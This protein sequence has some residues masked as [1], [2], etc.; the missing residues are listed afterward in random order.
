MVYSGAIKPQSLN[1]H[2]TPLTLTHLCP[3]TAGSSACPQ[4]AEGCQRYRCR[5]DEMDHRSGPYGGRRAETE[6]GKGAGWPACKGLSGRRGLGGLSWQSHSP[7]CYLPGWSLGAELTL[8]WRCVEFFQVPPQRA[9][10]A[11]LERGHWCEPHFTETEAQRSYV[12]CTRS[13]C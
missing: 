1:L 6:V 7:P 4:G 13:H 9:L 11:A 10:P 2:P 12:I 8:C 5:P 3:P